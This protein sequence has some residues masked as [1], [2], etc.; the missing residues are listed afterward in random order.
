[1][2]KK[3]KKCSTCKK[4]L[5]EDSFSARPNYNKNSTAKYLKSICR[6]CAV[7]LSFEW[8]KQNIEKYRKYQREY[9]REKRK[10]N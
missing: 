5:S 9:A 8:K 2:K 10:K 6:A 3:L 7:L 4:M 1:M